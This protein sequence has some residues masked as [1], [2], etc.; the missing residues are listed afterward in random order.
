MTNHLIFT[1]IQN[2]WARDCIVAATARNIFR[3]Y[4]DGTFRPDEPVSRA[5]FAVIL[6][7]AL[8][9]LERLRPSTIFLDV[10]SNHWAAKAIQAVYQANFLSGYRNRLFKPNQPIPRVQVIAALASGLNY[11][12]SINPSDTLKKYF[13]DRDQI[14]SYAV[15]AIAA[16]TERRIIVNYPKIKRLQPNKNATRGEIAAFICRVLK[17][18]AVPYKYI[19]GMEFVVIQPQ[20]DAADSFSEGMAQVK[21]GNKWGYI[22]KTG[23]LVISPQFEEANAFSAGLALVKSTIKS[24]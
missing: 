17:I 24:T 21:I 13:D 7:T 12:V 2:H 9:K 6:D 18:P 5:E 4:R 1:D 23:K 19:P 11:G 16:A 22:D 8:P 15:R 3:G 14:P 10:L 20:F